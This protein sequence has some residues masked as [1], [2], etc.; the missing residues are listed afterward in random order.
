MHRFA[1]LLATAFVLAHI[2]LVVAVNPAN[3][4]LLD[5]AHAPNRARAATGALGVLIVL[6][7][8]RRRRRHR[9][10]VWR[11]VLGC[12]RLLRRDHPGWQSSRSGLANRLGVRGL[13]PPAPPRR[14]PSVPPY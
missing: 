12:G 9:Y 14:A 11:W 7:V 4:G 3:L 10:E 2:V 8:L 5:I 13:E 6:T 1:G